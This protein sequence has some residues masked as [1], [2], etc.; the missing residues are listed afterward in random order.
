MRLFTAMWPSAEAVAAIERIERPEHPAVRWTTRDQWHLT[1]R[2]H[3]EV[4][5]ADVSVLVES[6]HELAA[7]TAPRT[8]VL[9]P[10]TRRVR[11]SVLVV[12]A[13]GLDD[14]T[15]HAH[16][17]LARARGRTPLPHALAGRPV[18]VSWS[19][20]Q[21]TLVRSRLE[22]TGA[23]YDTLATVPLTG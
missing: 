22:P 7:T 9:G 19:V 23:R 21:V 16:L 11:R 10:A 14:L 1:I 15:E 8:V 5:D 6:L 4:A 12:P 17:T 3:G 18:E 13:I 2:F 20:D